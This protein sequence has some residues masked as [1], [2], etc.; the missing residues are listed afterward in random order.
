MQSPPNDGPAQRASDPASR[1]PSVTTAAP[2]R[3]A[4]TVGD[5]ADR[6]LIGVESRLLNMARLDPAM[7]QRRRWP[8]APAAGPCAMLNLAGSSSAPNATMRSAGK[9]RQQP[10]L[11]IAALVIDVA[12]HH[13]ERNW[14]IL[15]GTEQEVNTVLDRTTVNAVEIQTRI[16]DQFTD[17]FDAE[18]S[19]VGPRS[20]KTSGGGIDGGVRTTACTP[21][22]PARISCLMRCSDRHQRRGR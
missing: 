8:A 10:R 3:W 6:H 14:S 11:A 15:M 4:R 19:G 20:W 5:G 18:E 16:G 22:M 21:P 2:P 13:L 7:Q 12:P 1:W 17:A 9:P